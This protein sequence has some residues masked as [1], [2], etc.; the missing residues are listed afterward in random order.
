MR[1][2]LIGTA[3]LTLSACGGGG[4]RSYST[5]GDIARAC[6]ASDRDA[7]NPAVCGCI[8]SVAN[9]ELSASDRNRI[10]PFFA[11][12][13]VAHAVRRSDTD[14][15]DAFWDRY[16]DFSRSVERTCG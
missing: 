8:Q 13:E 9:A 1:F 10:E 16:L 14:R 15:D 12:P 3:L 2:L 5:N 7:A 11:D 4:G 6:L